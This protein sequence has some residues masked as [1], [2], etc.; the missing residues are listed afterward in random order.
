MKVSVCVPTLN[1]TET[2]AP[3]STAIKAQTPP[4]S[5]TIVIDSESVDGTPELAKK[6]GFKVFQI[7]RSAFNHGA[8]RRYA[9][10][11]A[12]HADILVFLTQDAVLANAEALSKLVQPFEDPAVVA[13]YGRQLPRHEADPFE[14]HARLFNYPPVSAT[15]SL[16]CARSVGFRSVFFSNSFGA[17]RRSALESIG[18]FS[19]AAFGEDTIAVAKMILRGGTVCYSSDAHAYHSH[20]YSARQE[21]LRYFEIGRLH[22]RERLLIEHFGQASQEGRQFAV[23]ELRFLLNV[24]PWLIPQSIVRS[25]FKFLGY[26]VGRR[27]FPVRS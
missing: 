18:W 7:P 9:A 3:F 17:Y 5:E 24:A 13:S 22:T 19:D 23:S 27:I 12:Q 16:N 2:W 4:V 25:G 10:T 26:N 11:L 21:F 1:A 15:R 20:R 6:D 14:T 8:T